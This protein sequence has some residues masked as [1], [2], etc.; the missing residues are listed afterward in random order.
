MDAAVAW[1]GVAAA[2]GAMVEGA[3]AFPGPEAQ[4]SRAGL[5]GTLRKDHL[6]GDGTTHLKAAYVVRRRKSRAANGAVRLRPPNWDTG[7]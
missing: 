3:G 7:H 1:A 2:T 6:V 4:N 5:R